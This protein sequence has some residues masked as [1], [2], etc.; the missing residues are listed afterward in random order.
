MRVIQGVLAVLLFSRLGE[1]K[2]QARLHGQDLVGPQRLESSQTTQENS[3][4]VSD[5]VRICKRDQCHWTGCKK[6]DCPSG[7]SQRNIKKCV[8]GWGVYN[9][10]YCCKQVTY[11][12]DEP[13][14]SKPTSHPTSKPTNSPTRTK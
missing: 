4:A 11:N 14:T 10:D 1:V 6:G 2:D 8:T 12:C 3:L 13:P 9:N 5:D 7:Y